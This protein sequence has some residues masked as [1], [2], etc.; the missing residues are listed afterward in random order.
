MK[1]DGKIILAMRRA[2]ESCGGAG[3]LG[4]RLG[5]DPSC[6]S[7]YLGGRVKSV[8]DENWNKLKKILKSFVCDLYGVPA[9][10]VIDWQELRRD[11][12]MVGRNGGMERMVLRAQGLRMAPQICDQD[13]IVVR[14]RENLAE[15][16]ENKI[17]VAVF[18][19]MTGNAASPVCKRLRRLNGC[20]WLFSDEPQGSCLPAEN[21]RIYWI[22]VVLRKICEL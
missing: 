20:C 17:V 21:D 22:G 7:R 6:I 8:S 12:G 1:L 18:K 14:R 5:I 10:P 19:N 4:H 3:E 11:P 16:P 9:L 13:L 2:A 15:V